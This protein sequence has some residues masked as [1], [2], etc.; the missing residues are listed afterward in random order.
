[1][2]RV[3]AE[4]QVRRLRAM[5]AQQKLDILWHLR[6]DAWALSAAGVRWR[7][8]LLPEAE[9]QQRVRQLFLRGRS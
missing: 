2:D 1:M 7:E 5:G 6:L 9:V 4:M 8:P 3:V